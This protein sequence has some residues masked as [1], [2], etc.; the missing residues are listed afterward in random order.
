MS[1]EQIKKDCRDC[2]Y[3]LGC[4]CFSGMP[5]NEFEQKHTEEK[6]MLNELYER[7]L[8]A[9]YI[10]IGEETASYAY[11]REGKTLYIYFEWSN[12]KT[13]WI[14]NFNF[15]AKPYRKMKN[16]WFAHR[17]FLKV[18]KVIE[19]YLEGKI[20]DL[21]IERIIIGGYSHGAAI[22]VLCHEYCKFNRPDAK[23]EGYGYGCP[24]VVWGFLRKAVK[25]RFEGFTVIRNGCD[26]VTKV[27]PAI[28]GYR[29]IGNLL[30]IGRNK[31]Y[32]PIESHYPENYT[33]E[34]DNESGFKEVC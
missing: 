14:N 21:D 20:N 12:G 4:E 34:L 9:E 23:I 24:R 18:W 29:H 1:K 27:P 17:G 30:V 32:N 26:L 8:N 19:P 13:D 31:G 3:F 5:C 28:L 15:P 25:K 2:R 16:K 22:A 7:V 11:E 6:V 33:K 10:H